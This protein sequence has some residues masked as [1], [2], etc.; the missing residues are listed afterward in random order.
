MNYLKK[1]YGWWVSHGT[2]ILGV[3]QG[4]V[5]II[6]ATAGVIPESQLK[7]WM[8]ASGLMTFWRGQV[9]SRTATLP[10]PAPEA[11]RS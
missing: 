8:L 11:S 9:N 3:A 10:P 2:R 4:S 1:I 7:W 6:A 5:A